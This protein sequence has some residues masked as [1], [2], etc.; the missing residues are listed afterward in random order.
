MTVDLHQTTIAEAAALIARRKLSPVELTEATLARVE[1]LNPQLNA[2]LTVTAE[3]ARAAARTAASRLRRGRPGPLVGI[4]FTVK[5]LVL[6]EAAP[7]TLGSRIVGA[8]IEAAADAPAVARLRRAGAIMIGKAN[9]HEIALGVTTVNEH[10]GPARNPWNRDRIA[11]GSSGGSAVAVAAGFGLASLGTDTRGSIRIPAACCGV[12]GF[13]PTF[14]AV[15]TEGVFPLA[16][17]LDH[18]GPLTR[19]VEDAALVFSAMADAPA[20]GRRALAASRRPPARPKIAVAEYFLRDLDDEVGTA[21]DRAL[22]AVQR[23]GARL[24]AVTLPALEA[25][26][27]ASR[28]I[29]GAESLSYHERFLADRAEGY[30]P[31]VRARLESGAQLS[32]VQLVRAEEERLRLIAEFESLFRSVDALI[33]ASLPTVAPVIGTLATTF[34]SRE[35]SLADAFCHFNAPANLTGIP[36][37]SVPCG[38]VASGLPVALQIMAGFG[39]DD[40][41]L[42][43]AA[44]VERAVG[45][46]PMPSL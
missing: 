40:R 5:D 42:G 44:A 24:S 32:A 19:T 10:F 2:L 36:A 16:A 8:G 29:V 1:R 3:T 26:L 35:V 7:T 45:R 15:T 13:K 9:L 18:I 12:V 27:E 22:R 39:R 38:R 34:G 4:P 46:A 37:V 25:A 17:T 31:L 21:I 30:G 14:G 33:G 20:A 28:V 23:R 41:A 11:G 43:V 6:T